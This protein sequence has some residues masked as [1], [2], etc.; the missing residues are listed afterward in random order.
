MRLIPKAISFDAHGTLIDSRYDP[1][2][3]LTEVLE[4]SSLHGRDVTTYPSLFRRRHPDYL[5]AVRD[6]GAEGR[7]RFWR[8]FIQ[9]LLDIP[10]ATASEIADEAE[11]RTFQPTAGIWALYSDVMP[12]LDRLREEKVRLVV[13]SNWDDTI[14]DVLEMLGI[15]ERFEF[16]LSSLEVGYEKPDP[17]IFAVAVRRLG[18]EPYQIAHVGD[19]P[20]DDVM[21]ARFAGMFPIY[22]DRQSSE[23]TADCAR[24]ASLSE[25][26][27][28]YE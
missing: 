15:S 11:R 18:Y 7:R 8:S 24:I 25:L 10:I 27:R 1:V 2:R 14:H 3:L 4:E 22:L 6:H 12:I 21:G 26:A 17:R 20:K 28:L 23:G 16:V 9:E 19:N 5:E 13:V